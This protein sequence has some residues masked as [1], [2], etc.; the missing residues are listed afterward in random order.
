MVPHLVVMISKLL[1]RLKLSYIGPL[2]HLCIT[3]IYFDILVFPIERKKKLNFVV[4]PNYFYT[5][6]LH[7]R[8]CVEADSAA[9]CGGAYIF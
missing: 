6:H 7:C 8:L 1:K 3:F 9:W 4:C 2:I 5:G